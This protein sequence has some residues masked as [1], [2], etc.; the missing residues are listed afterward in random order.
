M[1]RLTG[2]VAVAVAVA[3][4]LVLPHRYH[5]KFPRYPKDRRAVIPFI[6]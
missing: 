3:V 1:S 5:K 6:W 2:A 4:R